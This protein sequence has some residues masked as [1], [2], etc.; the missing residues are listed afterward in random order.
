[1]NK[2]LENK[3]ILFIS[4]L[5]LGGLFIYA[6]A[7]KIIHPLQFAQI[8]HNYRFLPPEFIN[9]WAIILP[10][11]EFIAGLMLII[12]LRTK[13][14]ILLINGLLIIF[15]VA[16]AVTAARGIN[17]ACGCF[18]TSLQAKSN[19][20]FRIFEDVGMLILGIYIFFFTQKAKEERIAT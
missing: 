16:L 3:K 15:M 7:D 20:I 6:S 5:I 13:A 17:V 10:W 1:M 9:I 19:L 4:R 14:S 18:T 12:G 8:V 11:M 2:F